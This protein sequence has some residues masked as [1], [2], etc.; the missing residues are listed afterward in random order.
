MA[1]TQERLKMIVT[2]V[3]HGQSKSVIRYYEKNQVRFH[4]RCTGRGTASSEL[5]DVLGFGGTEREVV[6]SLAAGSIADHLMNKLRDEAGE[7]IRA[8]GIAFMMPL[9]AISNIPGVPLLQQGAQENRK[10]SGDMSSIK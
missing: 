4:Y 3:G 9:S 7:A 6:F 8:K 5:L 2:I 1:Q 10:S